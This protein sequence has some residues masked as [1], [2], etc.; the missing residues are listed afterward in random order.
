MFMPIMYPPPP[1]PPPRCIY[2]IVS[3]IGGWFIS[4]KGKEYSFY[5]IHN[6]LAYRSYNDN[7]DLEILVEVRVIDIDF[8][9]CHLISSIQRGAFIA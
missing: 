6:D 7:G 4:F 9:A 5:W 3:S 2:V 1:P 8:L